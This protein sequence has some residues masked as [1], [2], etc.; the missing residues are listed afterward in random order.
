MIG[1]T[2][3]ARRG[4]DGSGA[5]PPE[6]ALAGAAVLTGLLAGLYYAYACSVMPGLGRAHDRTFVTAMRDINE[7]ILNPGFFLSFAGAPAATTFAA[8]MLHRCGDARRRWAL[9]ALGG[10][11]V[12]LAVTT[13][14]SVP[15]NEA[16]ARDGDRAAFEAPWNL[17]NGARFVA[18]T[19][20]LGCLL[21][22]LAAPTELR[23]AAR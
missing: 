19:A 23:C 1:V 13:L 22:C 11:G 2:R 6:L 14:V 7:A 18:T 8:L 5:Q 15:L 3:A 21:R 4:R 16:L 12:G 9:A 10:H 20:A 17:A